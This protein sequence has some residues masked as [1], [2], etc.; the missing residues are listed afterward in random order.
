MC[1]PPTTTPTLVTLLEQAQHADGIAQSDGLIVVQSPHENNFAMPLAVE[2]WDEQPSD[3]LDQWQEAFESHLEV[4][5]QL[6]YASPTVDVTEI[7]VPPGSYHAL[8]TGR[9]FITHGWPGDTEPGDEW[10]IRLWPS[11]GPDQAR[12]LRAF[13]EPDDEKAAD[14]DAGEEQRAERARLAGLRIKADLDRA[15]S[16]RVLSGDLG[17]AVVDTVVPGKIARYWFLVANLDVTRMRSAGEAVVGEWF[18]MSTYDEDEDPITGTNGDIRCQW[19]ELDDPRSV[20]LTWQWLGPEGYVFLPDKEVAERIRGGRDVPRTVPRLAVPS[21]LR[22]HFTDATTAADAPT[23]RV[24]LEHDQ[25]PTEWIDDL[26]DFWRAKIDMWAW[27]AN[28]AP[29]WRR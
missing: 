26:A 6:I 12:R 16:A 23:T 19:T 1:I 21:T 7:E 22:V 27:Q 28:Y 9:G 24:H 8:I 5:D 29:N 4:T 15:P 3:D 2:V 20:A 18:E 17:A 11:A 10:R 25:V 13:R 14:N